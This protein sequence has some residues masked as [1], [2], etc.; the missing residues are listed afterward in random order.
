MGG[1]SAPPKADFDSYAAL[2]IKQSGHFKDCAQ[3][4]GRKCTEAGDLNGLL[5]FPLA[6]LIPKIGQAFAAK[7]GQ[8]QAGMAGVADRARGT[9]AAYEQAEHTNTANLT[10]IGNKLFGSPIQGFPDLGTIP[11]LRHLGTFDDE[12][13]SFKEPDAAGDDT[14]KDISLQLK[15]LSGYTDSGSRGIQD[16]AHLRPTGLLGKVN[17]DAGIGNWS[18]KLL[19]MGDSIFRHFTGQ[20]L[21]ALLF[22]PIVG[23][24]GRLK[25]LEE[26]YD[27]LSDAIYTV[28]GTV[29][30]GSVRLGGEWQG[31]TAR[32]FDSLM[33]RWSMGS[34]GLGDAAKIVSHMCRDGYYA[35]CALVQTALQ[36]ITRLINE[37]VKQLIETAAGDAAIEAVGGGPEDPVAD[38]VA[39]A[40][41]AYRIY[42][43]ISA[44][45][46][47][48]Q[49]IMKIY[50]DIKDAVGKIHHDVQVVIDAF[51][52]PLDIPGTI[53]SLID[54]VEQR[55][56]EFEK[57]GGWNPELGVARV[58]MLPAA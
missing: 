58:A 43:I 53:H 29:R 49:E 18:G 12:D 45:I 13:I 27:Q 41:T 2:M 48:V 3:W 5:V 28:A 15:L 24:Y 37:E 51:D 19:A 47:A 34:G 55:G 20:S 17:P 35:I 42:K 9:G 32:A 40:W 23:N 11:G 56:F 4:A 1:F 54:D 16:G 22:D 31:D 46:K 38:V 26:A 8:C 10:S 7:L 50:D 14:A 57:N 39:A 36:A 25:Y 30:K 33:F 44:I 21:V 52:S 6:L